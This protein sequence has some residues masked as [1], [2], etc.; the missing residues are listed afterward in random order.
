MDIYTDYVTRKQSI[1]ELFTAT[2]SASEGADEGE[3]IGAFV[4]D[5]METTPS[6]DLFVWSAYEEK[7]LLGCIFFSRLT[8][9]QDERTVFILSPVAVKTDCQ[10]SGIGQKLI[11]H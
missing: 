9:S 5:L 8:F 6:N 4:C 10:K 7:A 11:E 3:Q 2:F 1:I